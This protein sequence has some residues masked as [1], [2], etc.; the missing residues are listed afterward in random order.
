MTCGS[1]RFLSLYRGVR[2]VS[3][4]LCT[5]QTLSWGC[6]CRYWRGSLGHLN[7]ICRSWNCRN[8]ASSAGSS[9]RIAFWTVTGLS[10]YGMKGPRFWV[11]WACGSIGMPGMMCFISIWQ[12]PFCYRPLS[13]SKP[14]PRITPALTLLHTTSAKSNTSTTTSPT[15]LGISPKSSAHTIICGP[16]TSGWCERSPRLSCCS[17]HSAGP[18]RLLTSWRISHW[19]KKWKT[20]P[21]YDQAIPCKTPTPPKLHSR[22]P[23]EMTMKSAIP[24][25]G[26]VRPVSRRLH[27]HEELN[28]S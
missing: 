1:S 28:L 27:L 4:H 16:R 19:F 5:L 2:T 3:I 13:Q 14:N 26:A 11:G 21:E 12:L 22:Y 25:K 8:H 17:T 20:R 18:P 24:S 6:I 9:R 7:A 10:R 23:T 15:V